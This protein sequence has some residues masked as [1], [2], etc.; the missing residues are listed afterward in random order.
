MP[1]ITKKITLTQF[2]GGSGPTYLVE[3]SLDGGYNYTAS[4]DCTNAFLPNV[5]SSVNCSID[6]L[7]TNI[8]LTS[9]NAICNNSV[10]DGG[11]TTTT[12]STTTTSTTTTTCPPCINYEMF[13]TTGGADATIVYIDCYNTERTYSWGS[14]V[15]HRICARQIVSTSNVTATNSGNC[16][17]LPAGGILCGIPSL[18]NCDC[19][20]N[21]IAINGVNTQFV[22]YLECE[23]G[24][25]LTTLL[26]Y[27][28]PKNVTDCMVS[29]SIIVPTAGTFTLTKNSDCDC[30]TTTTTTTTAGPTTTTTTAAGTTTTTTTAAP[31]TTTTTTAPTTTTTTTAAPCSLT[32]YFDVSQSPGT[33][34]WNS[35]TDACQG[36]GTPLTVYFS[37]TPNGCPTTFQDVFNDGK[38]I[39]TNA[40]L[41]TVLAGNDKYYKSVSAP[42]SGIAIQV[43]NDGFIDTLSG[44][45]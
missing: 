28:N 21:T 34:G 16:Q 43:G 17:T 23:T 37:N 44:P 5:S 14:G 32:I 38:A 18:D 33:Q 22:Y 13:R 31:T 12:T 26:S 25:P 8:R 2:G 3:Y 27:F 42:N 29:G 36:T 4:V 1:I 39:Y 41:T 10:A 19:N 40:A 45:C 35:S 11:T 15:R 9:L 24:T 30:I 7:A 20:N 6:S